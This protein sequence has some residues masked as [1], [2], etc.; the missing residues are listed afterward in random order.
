MLFIIDVI[1]LTFVHGMKIQKTVQD[2]YGTGT[3]DS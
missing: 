1:V 2:L 3:T